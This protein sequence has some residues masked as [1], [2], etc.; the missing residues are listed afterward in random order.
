MVS[1]SERGPFPKGLT[2]PS[3][4]PSSS[5]SDRADGVAVASLDPA[6]SVCTGDRAALR[7]GP[8]DPGTALAV[9]RTPGLRGI[10]LQDAAARGNARESGKGSKT[11]K[12]TTRD[13]RA[14]YRFRDRRR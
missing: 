8:D 13:L 3:S 2:M 4:R 14:T 1:V 12:A 7:P 6:H 11:T 10:G 9:I 5:S